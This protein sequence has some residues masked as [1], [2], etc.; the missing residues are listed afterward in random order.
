MCQALGMR[1]AVSNCQNQ[2]IRQMDISSLG[3]A[4]L[5]IRQ[6][7]ALVRSEV[8]TKFVAGV[9]TSFNC[10]IAIASPSY[11]PR[12]CPRKVHSFWL[13]SYA[14][15]VCLCLPIMCRVV[16]ASY[17]ARAQCCRISLAECGGTTAV[18][19]TQA[20]HGG[21]LDARK[22]STNRR[23]SL[24]YHMSTRKL[25]TKFLCLWQAVF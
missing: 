4:I 8:L 6:N 7:K 21:A 3:S 11:S 17:Y 10:T 12:W 16:V 23:W 1:R 22:N 19:T 5:H 20:C 15:C 2:K 24:C 13:C 9:W 25:A 14:L 18:S